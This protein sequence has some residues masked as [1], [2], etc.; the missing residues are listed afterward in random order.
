M[1]EIRE[2]KNL[3]ELTAAD[4]GNG[5]TTEDVE[6]FKV[7]VR[8]LIHRDALDGGVWM[9]EDAV[10]YCFQEGDWRRILDRWEANLP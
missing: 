1:T 2:I 4:L 7:W 5:A 6:R 8:A 3:D 9:M 10:D